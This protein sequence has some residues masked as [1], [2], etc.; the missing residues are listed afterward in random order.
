MSKPLIESSKEFENITIQFRYAFITLRVYIY[1]CMFSC[2]D[3]WLV[4]WLSF[5]NVFQII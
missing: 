5:S 4:G 1:L 2:V 3:M